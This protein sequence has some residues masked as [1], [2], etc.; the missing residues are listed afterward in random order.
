[1]SVDRITGR[2]SD[3][4]GA[5]EDSRAG[6]LTYNELLA[7]AGQRLNDRI[8]ELGLVVDEAKVDTGR[9]LS[10]AHTALEDAATRYNSARYRANGTWKRGDPDA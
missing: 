3:E 6:D 4:I 7:L 9:D 2:T 1:M 5:L 10:L 8:A